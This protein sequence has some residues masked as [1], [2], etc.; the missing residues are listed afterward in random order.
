MWLNIWNTGRDSCSEEG[1]CLAPIH[2]ACDCF[3][4]GIGNIHRARETETGGPSDG[5]VTPIP[6]T[7]HG[8]AEPL[9][10]VIDDDPSSREF[11]AR[12]I[13]SGGMQVTTAASGQDGLDRA[14][15]IRPDAIT[16]DVFMD[17]LDGWAVL[18]AVKS[19]PDLQDIPVIMCSISD[20]KEAFLS[21]GAVEFM[22][23]PVRR[24]AYLGAIRRLGLAVPPLLRRVLE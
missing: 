5:P 2:V 18:A 3:S 15:E 8:R 13:T 22:T 21:L 16:L 11:L 24:E 23:K 10:L 6:A 7:S 19:D 12:H 17:G 14:R 20:D 9:V 4:H 1:A